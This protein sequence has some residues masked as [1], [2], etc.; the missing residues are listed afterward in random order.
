MR[1][2]HTQPGAHGLTFVCTALCSTLTGKPASC[3]LT[4]RAARL[5]ASQWLLGATHR[6]LG[7]TLRGLGATLRGL[8]A[9]HRGLGATQC[10]TGAWVPH[11]GFWVPLTWEP[12]NTAVAEWLDIWLGGAAV[13]GAP[14]EGRPTC[15]LL[16][17][18]FSPFPLRAPPTQASCQ[19][20]C[21][22]RSCWTAQCT[23]WRSS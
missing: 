16:P 15:P 8:G 6:G 14:R 2:G 5:Q 9:T 7:A 20:R 17:I 23:S 13:R 21:E 11:S 22:A 4:C 12:C 10:L 1:A 18:L 3:M 19:A